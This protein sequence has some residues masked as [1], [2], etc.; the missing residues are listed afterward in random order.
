MKG[1]KGVYIDW[2]CDKCGKDNVTSRKKLELFFKGI[3]K[4][5]QC[6]NC[7]ALFTAV[8]GEVK[9][10]HENEQTEENAKGMQS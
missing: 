8:L 2:K 1:I 5:L 6:K 3:K 4:R 7:G 10:D 9:E